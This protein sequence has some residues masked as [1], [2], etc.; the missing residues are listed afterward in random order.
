MV[1][2]NAGISPLIGTFMIGKRAGYGRES[3]APHNLTMT[4]A[5]ASQLV[6]LLDRWARSSWDCWLAS[7]AIGVSMV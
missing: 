6:V 1:H 7:S 5:G 2:I 4:M 3:M